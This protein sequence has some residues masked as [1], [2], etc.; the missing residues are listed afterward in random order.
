MRNLLVAAR[1]RIEASL[2]EAEAEAEATLDAG[3]PAPT[4]DPRYGIRWRVLGG[5]LVPVF[6]IVVGLTLAMAKGVLAVSFVAQSGTVNLTTDGL[7]GDDLGIAV[8][9][10]PTKNGSGASYNVRIGV[11]S[12][13][14]NGLCISQ[15]VGI[16]GQP[17]TLFIKGGD[18]D[19]KSFEINANGL[20]LDV[21]Q[22]RGVIGGSGELQVNKNGADV[23]LGSSGIDLGASSDRFGLQASTAQLKYISA[24]VRTISIPNLLQVPNFSFQVMPGTSE[25]PPPG[26]GTG[27]GGGN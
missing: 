26:S 10:I 17:Y 15:H 19:P 25:C 20:I 8:I 22:A 27:A 21:V 2:A 1:Q 24:T 3:G 9:R 5:V 11:G 12:G 13:R 6:A 16:L 18:K 7:S 4:T 23:T 14:I